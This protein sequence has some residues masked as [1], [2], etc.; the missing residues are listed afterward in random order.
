M[1]AEGFGSPV[2]NDPPF[3]DLVHGSEVSNLHGSP[4]SAAGQGF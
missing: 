1:V 3:D 2:E 4:T